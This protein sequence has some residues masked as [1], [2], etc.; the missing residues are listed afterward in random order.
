MK[1][2]TRNFKKGLAI[3]LSAA[4]V[5]GSVPLSSLVTTYADDIALT[6]SNVLLAIDNKAV[7]SVTYTGKQIT[8]DVYYDA[9]GDGTVNT[10]DL[11]L[12]DADSTD[13]QAVSVTYGENE[14]A[15]SGTV[16]ITNAGTGY[17][18]SGSLTKEFT[19]NAYDISGEGEIE[20][21]YSDLTYSG[22]EQKPTLTVEDK[23]SNTLTEQTDYYVSKVSNNVNATTDTSKGSITIKGQGNYTGSYT[24]SF[25]IS[26]KEI[27]SSWITVDPT[28]LTYTGAEQTVS[29]TVKDPDRD[30]TLTEESDYKAV[31]TDAK[32]GT[33]TYSVEG[34]GNYKTTTAITDTVSINPV[35]LSAENTYVGGTYTYTGEA[36]EPTIYWIGPDEKKGTEDDVQ[37]NNNENAEDDVLTV[38]CNSV[39]AGTGAGE[40]GI[41]VLSDN[42]KYSVSTAYTLSFDIEKLDLADVSASLTEAITYTGGEQKAD[43]DAFTYKV[44]NAEVDISNDVQ[45]TYADT[46]EAVNA[47]EVAYSIEPAT[48][49]ANVTGTL[50]GTYEIGQLDISSEGGAIELDTST[51]TYDGTVDGAKQAVNKVTATVGSTSNSELATTDYTVAYYDSYTDETTNTALTADAGEKTVVVTGTGNFKGTVKKT[52][53]VNA[54][55]F[56][57]ATVAVTG[58]YTYDG[59]TIAKPTP[60]VTLTGFGE[61]DVYTLTEDDYTVTYYDAYTSES[62]NTAITAA[63]GNKVIVVTPTNNNFTGVKV[64]SA[65]YTVEKLDISSA[66]ITIEQ[67]YNI[68]LDDASVSSSYFALTYNGVVIPEDEYE[69]NLPSDMPSAAGKANVTITAESSS[70]NLENSKTYEASFGASISDYTVELEKDTYT[71]TGSAIEPVVS[72]VS[73]TED[74]TTTTLVAGTDYDISYSNNEGVGT[75]T[76]TVTGIGNYA[77]TATT[78]FTITADTKAFAS[79][80]LTED[81]SFTY[82]GSDHATDLTAGKFTVTLANGETLEGSGFTVA[83]KD[84]AGDVVTAIKNA[85][86]YTV[87]ATGTGNYAGAEAS[88]TIRVEKADLSDITVAKDATTEKGENGGLLVVY[89][90]GTSG[91]ENSYDTNDTV[92][93]E[94]SIVAYTGSATMSGVAISYGDDTLASGTDYDITKSGIRN[95]GTATITITAKDDTNVKGTKTITYQVASDLSSIT[96]GTDGDVT[97]NTEDYEYTGSG[98]TPDIDVTYYGYDLTEGTDYTVA[99]YSDSAFS[100]KVD[101]PTDVGTYYV[102][103]IGK[104]NYTGETT[105]TNITSNIVAMNLEDIYKADRTSIVVSGLENVTYDEDVTEYEPVTGVTVNGY[106]LEASDYYVTYNNN[107]SDGSAN[108]TASVSITGNSTNVTGTISG[109]TFDI[110]VPVAVSDVDLDKTSASLEKGET[111][112]LKATFAPEDATETELTWK[113]SDSSVAT[114]SEDGVVTAVAKGTA[115]ITATAESGVE[116][117][118]EITVT[119][120]VSESATSVTLNKT[121]LALVVGK[122]ET[123]TA[124]VAPTGATDKVTWTSSNTAVA[125][126]SAEGVVTAVSEGET[127]IAATAGSVSASCKVTVSAEA[128][129]G[130]SKTIAKVEYTVTDATAN[131]VKVTGVKANKKGVV[132]IANTVTINGETYK[133]TEIAANAAKGNTS[134]KKVVIGKNIKK[135]GKNAFK[136]C[137]NLKSVVIRNAKNLKSVGKNAF[138][139]INAK[140]TIKI[141]ASNKKAFKN[142]K[143][144]IVKSGVASSVKMKKI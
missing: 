49:N 133:V 18:L 55:D 116:A 77:G 82:D 117:S 48:D 54:A 124:T 27:Q 42:A 130:E 53:T 71:Y 72:S 66:N 137:K 32:T 15:G 21:T 93:A 115:T 1:R 2:K 14:N 69:V 89:L 57:A 19:I 85:D 127:T 100:T 112:T 35:A 70:G 136:N 132:S 37:L 46:E 126:V 31:V 34:I 9:N 29:L 113:S 109:L 120:T 99:Y 78:T 25:D 17:S 84:S 80:A 119:E 142:A 111:L 8:P 81:A 3:S 79:L 39:S 128:S 123:L 87:T 40:A 140:A 114:V 65:A 88:T 36:Q 62:S 74:E 30:V 4:M 108:V 121:T 6:D 83:Y 95:V 118:C 23:N 73:K 134:I 139:N 68:A 110:V 75:G 28:S 91:T 122:S 51:L 107:T 76:V 45:V 12:Y 22:S 59:S 129:V 103:I 38:T 43:E 5:V 16:K 94:G 104:G 7:S 20:V 101:P 135:I 131:T 96:G 56:T 44:G 13:T 90:D 61:S 24:G 141:K 143:K 11:I 58:T 144:K 41:A 86:T 98:I 52:Y 106:T 47:G 102:K 97:V 92:I 60:T 105:A 50:T 10:G 26:Q 63:A 64:A 33:V 125:T 67:K 138:K